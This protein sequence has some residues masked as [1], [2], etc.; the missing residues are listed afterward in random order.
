MDRALSGVRAVVPPVILSAVLKLQNTQTTLPRRAAYALC[1][2]N[3]LLDGTVQLGG[4]VIG[5]IGGYLLLY[6][7]WSVP[8]VIC[9]GAILGMIL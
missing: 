2:T 1:R 4:I 7:K 3:Y 5:I 8:K 6:R 9:A